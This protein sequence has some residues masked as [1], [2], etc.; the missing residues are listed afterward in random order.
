MRTRTLGVC[1]TQHPPA[2]A[3]RLGPQT[4]R[5][6]N[7][8]ER[9]DQSQGRKAC[10]KPRHDRSLTPVPALRLGPQTL[11]KENNHEREDQSQG[12]K[13]RFKP[14]HDRS[15]TLGGPRLGPNPCCGSPLEAD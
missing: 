1:R 5:E 15:L 8:H 6:E 9:E 11:R 13:A 10:F 3:F 14:Q 7:N 12:R 4:L 2:P